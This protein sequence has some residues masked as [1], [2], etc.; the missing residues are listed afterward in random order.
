[1]P[2]QPKTFVPP[3]EYLERERKAEFKSEYLNGEIFVRARVAE[4]HNLL[5]GGA[6]Y[7]IHRQFLRRNCRVF[8]SDMRV[9]STGLFTYPD[10]SAVC[11]EPQF[12]DDRDDTLLNPALIVE[13][14]SVSTE[15]YDRGRKFDHYRSV[16]S[17]KQYVLVASDRVHVDVFTRDAVGRWVLSS[18]EAPGDE[19][20][21]GSIECRLLVSG[22]YDKTG[23]LSES[24]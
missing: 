6:L 17:L 21:L 4:T 11:G 5:A 18:F 19:I 7:L 14:L 24:P 15:A 10:L 13:V 22:L 23:L 1:M 16:P 20:E 12:L 9:G 3:E 8:G 2:T